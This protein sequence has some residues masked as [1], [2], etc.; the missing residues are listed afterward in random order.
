MGMKRAMALLGEG[1]AALPGAAE[2]ATLHL[3]TS[4]IQ[5]RADRGGFLETRFC[6]AGHV[7]YLEA[8]QGFKL[9]TLP[10]LLVREGGKGRTSCF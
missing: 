6:V 1:A 3:A 2:R 8:V 9:V 10:A 5:Q 4:E 7:H